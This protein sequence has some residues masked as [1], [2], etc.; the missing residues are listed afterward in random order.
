M[1]RV[2]KTRK[3]EWFVVFKLHQSP[4]LHG[5]VTEK[6]S[7]SRKGSKKEEDL[8]NEIQSFE[9]ASGGIRVDFFRVFNRINVTT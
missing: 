4:R 5:H 2:I 3:L 9:S 7:T 1:L 8:V 6:H